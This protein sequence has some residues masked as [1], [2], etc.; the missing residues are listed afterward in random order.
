MLTKYI[1]HKPCRKKKGRRFP[2]YLFL[3]HF[4]PIFEE[5]ER[6]RLL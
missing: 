6:I 4:F 1:I 3:Y 2:F 5:L